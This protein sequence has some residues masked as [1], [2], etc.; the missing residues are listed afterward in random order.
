[1]ESWKMTF[2]FLY[3]GYYYRLF[4]SYNLVRNINLPEKISDSCEGCHVQ[5]EVAD[6]MYG[7]FLIINIL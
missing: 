7:Y 3:T 5:G 2:I 6:I 4:K 1:M